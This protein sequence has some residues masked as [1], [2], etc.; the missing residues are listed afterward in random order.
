MSVSSLPDERF[1]ICGVLAEK[2]SLSRL[3]M[4]DELSSRFGWQIAPDAL[5]VLAP[6][7]IRAG[8][9]TEEMSDGRR[10]YKLTNLGRDEWIKRF[11][12]LL[13]IFSGWKSL[14]GRIIRAS[15]PDAERP[16]KTPKLQRLPN[17]GE[18][19]ALLEC[20][21]PDFKVLYR[22]SVNSSRNP[23]DVAAAKI[24]DMDLKSK[25][26]RLPATAVSGAKIENRVIHLSKK[27]LVELVSVAVGNRKR[28]SVFVRAKGRPWTS[29]DLGVVFRRTRR[30]AGLPEEIVLSGRGRKASF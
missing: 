30:R 18:I 5:S 2:G 14:R 15:L 23:N 22:F 12:F 21:P 13:P 29:D 10:F 3:A 26:I 17:S 8:L 11:D 1:L 9:L 27:V 6:K 4:V 25:I 7:L 16:S 24:E 19:V 28:G 20:A